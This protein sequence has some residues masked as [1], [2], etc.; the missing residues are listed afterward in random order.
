MLMSEEL[1]QK[2]EHFINSGIGDPGRL[3]HIKDSLL[4][5]KIL[6]TS[7]QKYLDKLVS[8]HPISKKIHDNSSDYNDKKQPDSSS[9][10][11][12]KPTTNSTEENSSEIDELKQNMSK[13]QSKI[14]DMEEIIKKQESKSNLQHYKSESTTLV[15][16]IVV[17][18]F[19]IMG[20]GHLYIGKIKRG[21]IIM[22]IGFSLWTVLLV[23][24]MFLGI[25]NEFDESMLTNIEFVQYTNE[26]RS[27]EE[28]MAAL[29]GLVAAIIVVTVG[30]LVL[31][32]WQIFDSRK[33][34]KKYNHHLEQNETPLW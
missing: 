25:S 2:I 4:K 31:F 9:E 20:V 13:A 12:D 29:I 1:L 8:E 34:C 10:E 33:L 22:L 11:L 30:Y 17:G 16:S 7:D 14:E 28:V 23:P 18:L 24:I 27:Q 21:V 19:G 26:K 3:Q 32:I 5:G 15:L 6:Y